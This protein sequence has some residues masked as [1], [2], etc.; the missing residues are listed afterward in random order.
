M[1]NTRSQVQEFIPL[2]ISGANL[3]ATRYTRPSHGTPLEISHHDILDA[4]CIE[5]A[6]KVKLQYTD[7]G[8]VVALLP[9]DL[10]IFLRRVQHPI[11]GTCPEHFGLLTP[12]KGPG[13]GGTPPG[14]NHRRTYVHNCRQSDC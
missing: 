4:W 7:K 5:A 6:F 1:R 9:A 3:L 10:L 14:R 8:P 13:S 12:R 11:P 2:G